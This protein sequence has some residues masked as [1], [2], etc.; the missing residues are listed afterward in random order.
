MKIIAAFQSFLL[1]AVT[2]ALMLGAF[3][4]ISRTA[5]DS[6]LQYDLEMWK[7]ATQVKRVSENPAIGHEHRPGAHAH[8]MG[9]DVTI[10]SRGL[11]DREITA[12]KREGVKRIVMLGDSLVFGWGVAQDKTM[13]VLLEQALNEG[14]YGPAEVINTGVGNYNTAMEVAFFLERGA[15]L[16]P[17]TV[18]LNY[19]INDA[20][21]T[22]TYVPAS[23]IARHSYGYVVLGGGWD[24]FKRLILG[25]PDWR[26]AYAGLYADGAPGWA[27]A[28]A[29]IG[30]LAEYCRAHGIRLVLANIP[31]LHELNPYPFETVNAKVRALASDNGI[32]YVDLL[33]AL[34]NDDAASLWVTVPDP[35]PNAKAHALIARS[36]ADYLAKTD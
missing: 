34:R 18:V 10:N 27:A 2:A 20:E 7:Y 17:D 4:L 29:S 21:P 19:F 30:R 22:P 31:E 13:S 9:A 33:P 16:K 6:G 3:E 23:W 15:D 28:R 1:I 8:L 35:H 12:E 14:S 26:S 24:R 36:L 5:L 25:G 32:E 11:R